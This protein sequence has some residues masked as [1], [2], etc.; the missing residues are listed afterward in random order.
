M[1]KPKHTV[2]ELL[3]FEIARRRH[4]QTVLDKVVEVNRHFKKTLIAISKKK[5]G[6]QSNC[7]FFAELKAWATDVLKNNVL[8]WEPK[9]DDHE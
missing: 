5:Y 4:L 6:G 7:G 1:E 9:G 2:E 8:E 3:T